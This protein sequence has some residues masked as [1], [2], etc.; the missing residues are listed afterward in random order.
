MFNAVAGIIPQWFNKRRPF[1]T[2]IGAT[3]SGMGG[4]IYSLATE[5][6]IRNISINWAY[7]ILTIISSAVC[8]VCALLIKDR[9]Q[10]VGT[11]CTPFDIQLLK[12]RRLLLT[13]G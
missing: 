4:L 12:H 13:L 10:S 3:G 8:I 11:V 9:N 1:A 6:I 7:R 2:S 5:G